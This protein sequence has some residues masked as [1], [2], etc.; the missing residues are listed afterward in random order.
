MINI[1]K[2]YEV[3]CDVEPKR[4]ALEEA[5]NELSAAQNRLAFVTSKIKVC[6]LFLIYFKTLFFFKFQVLF[7]F[8]N[9]FLGIRR[10]VSQVK[11]R[12]GRSKS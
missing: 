3:Y 7:S 4:R 9:D 5:N 10:T 12:V 2:F 6:I 1:I 8:N 11:G